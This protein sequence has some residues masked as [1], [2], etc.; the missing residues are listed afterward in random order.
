MEGVEDLRSGVRVVAV[1]GSQL[2][3]RSS[4]TWRVA[5]CRPVR[6]AAAPT[7]IPCG[8][9]DY[10]MVGREG[11]LD[12]APGHLGSREVL[13]QLGGLGVSGSQVGA[14][15]PINPVLLTAAMSRTH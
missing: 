14:V 10:L 7:G 4:A 2:V 11:G 9:D 15:G 12:G 1:D 6:A 8:T 5:R 3:I 13:V